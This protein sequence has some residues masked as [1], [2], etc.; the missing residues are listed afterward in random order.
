MVT[1]SRLRYQALRGLRRSFSLDLPSK[2]SQVHFTSL[3]VKGL[4]SCH[5][6][7]SRSRKRNSVLDESQDHS[8]ARSGTIEAK[9]ACATCWSNMTRLL[10]RPIAGPSAANVTSSWSDRLAG[11]SK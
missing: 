3:A 4:P 11:L 9:L 5:L 6:T 1:S 10:N 7:P 2:V 8:L